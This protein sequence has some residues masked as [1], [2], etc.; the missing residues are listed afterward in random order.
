MILSKVKI[1][2]PLQPYLFD[3]DIN[4]NIDVNVNVILSSLGAQEDFFA[5]FIGAYVASSDVTQTCSWEE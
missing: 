1:P 4:Y 2:S 5:T 3:N